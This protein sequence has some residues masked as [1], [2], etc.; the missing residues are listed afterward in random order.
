MRTNNHAL[1]GIQT[2]SLS[3]KKTWPTPQ[4]SR[5]LG[6]PRWGETMSQNS[7]HQRAYCS[8]PTRYMSMEQRWDDTDREKPQYIEENLLLL[9]AVH[10]KSHAD[11][12]GANQGLRGERPANDL[13]G[14]DKACVGTLNHRIIRA[15][16]TRYVKTCLGRDKMLSPFCHNAR[17]ARVEYY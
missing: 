9:Y 15:I 8:S 12:P 1:S 5:L 6:S 14:P 2:H 16:Q 4:I 10:H 3:S 7:G 11:W 13:L 17:G